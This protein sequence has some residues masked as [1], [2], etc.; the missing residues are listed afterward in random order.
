VIIDLENGGSAE[1]ETSQV[2]SGSTP[3]QPAEPVAQNDESRTPEATSDEPPHEGKADAG[4]PPDEPPTNT[5]PPASGE[6]PEGED[7]RDDPT[8]V[9]H[10]EGG[11]RL[12]AF[13]KEEQDLLRTYLEKQGLLPGESGQTPEPP[14]LSL[15]TE[16]IKELVDQLP[17]HVTSDEIEALRGEATDGEDLMT[18]IAR[19]ELVARGRTIDEEIAAGRVVVF[20]GELP[21]PP[22]W[23][24]EIEGD[25]ENAPPERG[26]GVGAEAD[27]QRTL[28][29]IVQDAARMTGIDVA[30]TP[31]NDANYTLLVDELSRFIHAD[32]VAAK[33]PEEAQRLMDAAHR[34]RSEAAA[35]V[36]EDIRG[37][38]PHLPLLEHEALR[39]LSDLF[40]VPPSVMDTAVVETLGLTNKTA[41]T[42]LSV[43]P[44]ADRRESDFT[45]T[46]EAIQAALDN[47]PKE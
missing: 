26:G 9:E 8:E 45:T 33:S 12:P 4:G 41:L 14:D 15:V 27:N 6:Q 2:A 21:K 25:P 17:L 13:T 32:A 1:S 31:G 20:E 23:K 11:F 34:L 38:G 16:S 47:R 35:H 5:P 36:P 22:G 46:R 18:Q 3:E 42:R 30:E 28:H 7:G 24:G 29:D 44:S 40:G 43:A 39:K 19:D 10:F 37:A